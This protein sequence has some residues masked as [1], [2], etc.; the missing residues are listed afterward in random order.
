MNYLIRKEQFLPLLIILFS[1]STVLA[2]EA[3]S[4][5]INSENQFQ[6]QFTK[7][8]EAVKAEN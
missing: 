3:G 2:N 6:E 7:G 8:V 1:I 5:N 4:E